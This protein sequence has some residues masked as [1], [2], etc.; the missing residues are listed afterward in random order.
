MPDFIPYVWARVVQDDFV[1]I[2]SISPPFS[3]DEREEATRLFRRALRLA[4]RSQDEE[5]IRFVRIAMS[6]L[7]APLK[8]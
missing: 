1:F 4:E 3:Q 8:K 7:A 5:T 6:K 2:C